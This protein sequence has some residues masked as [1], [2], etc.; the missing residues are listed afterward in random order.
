MIPLPDARIQHAPIRL[1]MKFFGGQGTIDVNS[2][3]PDST[4]FAFVSY[5]Q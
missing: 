2:W 1:L 4:R 5:E 3:A